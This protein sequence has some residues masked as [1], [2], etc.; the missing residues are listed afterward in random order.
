MLALILEFL[1]TCIHQNIELGTVH[2]AVEVECSIERTAA[3]LLQLDE[4]FE[5]SGMIILM[6]VLVTPLASLHMNFWHL[7]YKW[8]ACESPPPEYYL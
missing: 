5:G 8:N 3:G 4:D 2:D 6:S 7:S 1:Y